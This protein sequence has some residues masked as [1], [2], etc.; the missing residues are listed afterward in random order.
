[1]FQSSPTPKGGRYAFGHCQGRLDGLF[2]LFQ[3]SP[4][5][6]GG[7]YAYVIPVDGRG[8]P[9]FQSSPTPKGGR[10][11]VNFFGSWDVIL[12]QSSPTPKGGR[13]PATERDRSEVAKVSILAHPERWALP[14]V[15]M[16]LAG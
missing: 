12:F 5:P 10:Y 15:A 16:L 2:V 6:K 13:Y 1:M 7:R 9:M 4:T 3:S 14:L 11:A 8:L